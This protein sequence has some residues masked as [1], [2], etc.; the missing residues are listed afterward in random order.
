MKNL[1]LIV[2]YFLPKRVKFFAML[3]YFDQL[4]E[5]TRIITVENKDYKLMLEKLEKHE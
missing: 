2:S 3:D 1:A 5:G 4:P